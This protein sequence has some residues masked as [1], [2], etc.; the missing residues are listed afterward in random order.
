MPGVLTH[1]SGARGVDF[2]GVSLTVGR[3][4]RRA[5]A[6]ARRG[7]EPAGELAM[8]KPLNRIAADD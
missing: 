1:R 8:L 5:E 3:A 7:D 6:D 2:A 4:A